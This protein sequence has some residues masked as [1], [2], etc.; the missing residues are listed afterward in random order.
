MKRVV[1]DTNVLISATLSS[2]GNPAKVLE[3]ISDKQVSLY[4]S[5][6]ILEE[7]QR[8]LAHERLGILPQTQ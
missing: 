2:V 4:Y 6:E 1:I 8:V 3:L 7:F 5:K